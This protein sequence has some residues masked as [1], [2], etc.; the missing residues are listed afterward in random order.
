MKL[1]RRDLLRFGACTAAASAFAGRFG[2]LNVLAQSG[3]EY[4]A[5]VC[6]FLFGGNDANNLIV[7]NDAAGYANY[8]AL[9]TGLALPQASLLPIVT[10][11]GARPFGLHPDLPGVQSRFNAG[12]LAIVANVG[13]LVQPTTR[14]QYVTRQ[15]PVPVNLFSHS[16]QQAEWQSCVPQSVSETGWG[17]R[18]ADALVALNGT[19]FPPVSSVAGTALY[20]VGAQTRPAFINPGQAFAF[21]GQTGSV[22]ATARGSTMQQLLTFSSGVTLVQAASGVTSAAFA[23][24]TAL[25][26]ALATAPK[27]TTAWPS[28]LTGIASQL[29]DVATLLSVRGA[30]GLT[31]QIFFV[32]MGGFDT[33]TDELATH[34][35][36][37]P[38]LD[39]ALTAFHTATVE[40]GIEDAVTTFTLSEFGRTFLERSGGGSDHGWGSHHLVSGG[41]V[42]GGD[43]YGT[44]PTQ[45][46]GGTDDAT[47]DGRWIPSTSV[48]AYAA[49]LAAWF[50]VP[51]ASLPTAF[52]NLA[53]FGSYNLGFL[54]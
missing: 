5:L 41:A 17:G 53:S 38:Q 11:T 49:T 46:P 18:A 15:V 42:R 52:P 23:Q 6:V 1:T 30:L 24:S 9:R 20:C 40:L 31:R 2:A 47:N 16:D 25:S 51:A 8:A 13:T 4:K 35:R 7:P 28:P 3:S 19:L 54:G 22:P 43:L 37:Y 50:G 44:F 26:A 39:A 32:A 48:D 14:A 27:L 36:L 21:A 10:A 12:K 34:Q 33:H 45:T 29:Q